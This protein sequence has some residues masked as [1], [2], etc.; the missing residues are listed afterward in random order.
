LKTCWTLID[1]LKQWHVAVK[2]SAVLL[3][4]MKFRGSNAEPAAIVTE[5]FSDDPQFLQRN[6]RIVLRNRPRSLS[7]TTFPTHRWLIV[8]TFSAVHSELTSSL[9]KP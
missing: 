6:K 2:C 3:P 4:V 7:S 8:V 5:V 1:I 9:N